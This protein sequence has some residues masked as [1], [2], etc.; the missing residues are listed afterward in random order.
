M[1]TCWGSD[2]SDILEE[3]KKDF[4]DSRQDQSP[5]SEMIRSRIILHNKT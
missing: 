2:D 5:D 3:N 1:N 4:L